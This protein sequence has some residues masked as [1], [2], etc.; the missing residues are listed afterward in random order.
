MTTRGVIEASDTAP[1]R[2][3][4]YGAVGTRFGALR[5]TI[6][7]LA[8]CL[9]LQRF[10]LPLGAEGIS[11]AGPI[12]VA[13]AL[14]GLAQGTL[15]LHRGR[16]A[17]YLTLLGL[18]AIGGVWEA[19]HPNHFGIPPIWR[20]LAQFLVLTSFATL[21]FTEP[22]DEAIFFRAINRLLAIIAIAGI[23]QFVA[24]FAGL[25]LFSF[26]GLLPDRLLYEYGYNVV[27]PVG[28]G[29]V[30]KSNGVFL[31]EPSVFSQFMA[32][33]LIIEVLSARRVASLA[34]FAIGLLLSFSGTGWIVLAAFG[35]TAFLGL[36]R[37]GAVIGLGALLIL[38]IGF[39]AMMVLAP[40]FAAALSDR[41]TEF[42]TP[43]TSAHLRFITPV[44]LVAD[45]LAREPSALLVGIGAG[46]SERLTLP[47]LF[48]VDT[49]IK[50]L[51]EY[52]LPALLAY[53]A[54]FFRAE[55]TRNQA[56]LL[57]PVLVLFFFTGGYQQFPPV[58]FPVLLIVLVA[59]LRVGAEGQ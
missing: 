24:Q 31:M 52:G 26:V 33:G 28:I 55:R 10:A 57:V 29:D 18:V 49:P 2:Q 56:A 58:L 37:R 53:V 51:V 19:L 36:G 41:L 54:L 30:L 20:S 6:L 7:V 16:L 5:F 42:Q 21:A 23:L 50:I 34:L 48:N 9:F 8:A 32:L 3:G 15:R 39:A 47:Y 27:I 35:L 4:V 13:L 44:W 1:V 38:A 43:G 11:L 12:G 59:R 45:V 22:L 17:L 40:D 46:A 25:R 14:F